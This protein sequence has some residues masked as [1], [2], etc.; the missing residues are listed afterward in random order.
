MLT[1]SSPFGAW[2]KQERKCYS[3]PAVIENGQYL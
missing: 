3:E 1:F 2:T